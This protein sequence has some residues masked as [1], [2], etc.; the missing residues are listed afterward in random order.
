MGTYAVTGSASGMGG[1]VVAK[2]RPAGHTVIGVDINDA[3]IVADLSTP[4]GRRGAAAGVL[5]ACSGVLDG[6]VLAAGLGPT[7]GAERLITEVNYFGVVDLLAA[8]RP[9]LA[10]AER[11]KVVA[12]ASNSTTTVPAVPRR[13]IRALLAG[14]AERALR[15][16][17][18]FGPLSPPMAYAASKIAVSRWVRRHAVTPEWAGAGIRLNALAPGAIMTPMLEQQLAT[19]AEAKHVRQFPVPIGGFGD[20]GQLADWVVFMLSD[21]AD[22]LCGSVVFVDGGSDAYFRADDWPRPVPARRAVSY[23]RRTRQFVERNRS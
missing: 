9:A 21:S 4:G 2:L 16:Y 14:D 22:F 15:A 13:A 8:W 23:L 20:P 17:R 11:A 12:F 10:A 18:F 3:E 1:A 6:A 19:P 7:K 5:A